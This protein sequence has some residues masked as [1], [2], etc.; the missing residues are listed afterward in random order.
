MSTTNT[1][2]TGT[3]AAAIFEEDVKGLVV[4][5]VSVVILVGKSNISI[6][7]L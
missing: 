6:V 3:T 1:T 5:M 2:I 7:I 4:R